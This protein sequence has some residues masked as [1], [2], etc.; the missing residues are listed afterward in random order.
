VTPR[1]ESSQGSIITFYSYKGGSGRTMALANCAYLLSQRLEQRGERAL[2]IDWD[3]EAPGLHEFFRDVV[4][5]SEIKNRPG[6]IDYFHELYTRISGEPE[7]YRRVCEDEA[8]DAL[9]QIVSLDDHL[10]RDILP[11]IDIMKAG[12]FDERYAELV[13]TFPWTDL[14]GRY[15]ETFRLFRELVSARFACCLVDSRTG[16]NDTSGICTMLLPEKLVGVFAPNRQSLDGLVDVLRQAVAYR[17][18]SND[19]RPLAIYPLPSRIE[20]AEK[21]LR[22]QWRTRYQSRFEELFCEAYALETCD[23]TTYVNEVQLPHVSFYAYGETIAL[24][25]ER[26]DSLSLRRAYEKFFDWLEQP[27]ALGASAGP[28]VVF[29]PSAWP[30]ALEALDNGNILEGVQWLRQVVPSDPH[31]LTAQD[32][33]AMYDPDDPEVRDL[34]LALAQL[35]L[36]DITTRLNRGQQDDFEVVRERV[37]RARALIDGFNRRRPHQQI[38]SP[39]SLDVLEQQAT[40]GLEGWETWDRCVTSLNIADPDEAARAFAAFEQLLPQ[41]AAL[42]AY[43]MQ[44]QEIARLRQAMSWA[45]RFEH[46]QAAVE[47]MRSEDVD[48]AEDAAADLTKRARNL[49]DGPRIPQ[50]HIA[51]LLNLAQTTAV[52]AALQRTLWEWMCVR[53][54]LSDRPFDPAS[55][56]DLYSPLFEAVGAL[57]EVGLDAASQSGIAPRFA[58]SAAAKVSQRLESD[59][60]HL[61]VR[62]SALGLGADAVPGI[63]AQAGR[64]DHRQGAS[65]RGPERTSR[66]TRRTRA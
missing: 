51:R 37:I 54:R 49:V 21:M 5:D 36:F 52:G 48:G 66:S 17:Q 20:L 22:D 50:E 25:G 43:Q 28:T 8:W 41:K 65:V 61:L 7:L 30:R 39:A 46:R 58:A 47:P 9:D 45:N 42:P 60:E 14:F 63:L 13:G 57:R 1:T 4:G 62:V 27:D 24:R 40:R 26:N 53:D 15:G 12:R 19:L 64:L 38:P 32:Y 34:A 29:D 59:A 33:L 44:Q 10:I 23:L 6:L 16:L 3:L 55:D 2:L 35:L 56:V 18:A 31:Y 11:G